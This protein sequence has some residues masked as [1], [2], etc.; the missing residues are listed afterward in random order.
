MA[1]LQAEG[2]DLDG[3]DPSVNEG[4]DN[5]SKRNNRVED[6]IRPVT[7]LYK[8]VPGPS[9][10]SY[11]INVARMAGIA[12]KVL[13]EAA[14]MSANIALRAATGTGGGQKMDLQ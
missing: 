4:E 7:F 3:P 13:V 2:E 6:L 8:L 10:L 5:R 9:P 1:Y 11:G 12:P 14:K